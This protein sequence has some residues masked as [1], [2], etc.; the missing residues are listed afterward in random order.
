MSIQSTKRHHLV[1][2]LN[3]KFWDED[4]EYVKG[5]YRMILVS[6]LQHLLESFGLTDWFFYC[7]NK[8]IY[9]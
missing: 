1:L 8:Y 3:L 9:L 2:L 5:E 4:I 6:P 7:I